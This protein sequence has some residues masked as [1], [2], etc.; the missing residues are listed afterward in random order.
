MQR[1][2]KKQNS[3]LNSASK[4]NKSAKVADLV[5][6]LEN[7]MQKRDDACVED[8]VNIIDVVYEPD[9]NN[10]NDNDNMVNVLKSQKLSKSIKKK[11]LAK[12]FEDL[13][14]E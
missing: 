10:D 14:N 5:K 7:N 8:E 13:E 2:K 6:E 9:D 3:D 4:A 1:I 11:K 12:A